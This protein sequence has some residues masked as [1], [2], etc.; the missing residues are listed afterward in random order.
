[1]EGDIGVEVVELERLVRSL[2]DECVMQIFRT[3]W[4]ETIKKQRFVRSC[5]EECRGKKSSHMEGCGE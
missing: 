2:L 1:V 3:N 4:S 5:E